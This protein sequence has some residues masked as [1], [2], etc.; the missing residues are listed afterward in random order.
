MR[1]DALYKM[2]E[3]RT[4]LMVANRLST[5]QHADNIIVLQK[6]KIRE[7]GDHQTL[8]AN[9]GIYYNLYQLA[10]KSQVMA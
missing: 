8:L 3:A 2:M 1:Q 9:E 7:M 5:I 4:T 6:G 10:L